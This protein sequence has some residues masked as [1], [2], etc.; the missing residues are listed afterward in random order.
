MDFEDFKVDAIPVPA[1]MQERVWRYWI[2]TPMRSDTLRLALHREGVPLDQL[3]RATQRML[4]F[5]RTR[6]MARVK[7]GFYR[8][9]EVL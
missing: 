1:S 9:W 4:R 5:V 3:D 2:G 7:P 6:K 8:T